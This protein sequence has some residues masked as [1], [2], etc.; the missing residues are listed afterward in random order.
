M[1]IVCAATCAADG[2]DSAASTMVG[3]CSTSSPWLFGPPLSQKSLYI[4]HQHNRYVPPSPPLT[5]HSSSRAPLGRILAIT[6]RLLLFR[7][8]A[9]SAPRERVG[10]MPAPQHVREA[11]NDHVCSVVCLLLCA[12]QLGFCLSALPG[13]LGI[14][15][16][17]QSRKVERKAN[18]TP[19]GL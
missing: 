2:D 9:R 7:R 10:A 17:A 3:R 4:I 13:D 18:K 19:E 1:R 15:L 16:F 14:C 5:Y 6:T 8:I 12:D 11:L